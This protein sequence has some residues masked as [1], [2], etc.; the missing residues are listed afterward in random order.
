MSEYFELIK[1]QHTIFALPFAFSGML[2]ARGSHEWPSFA[3]FLWV[4]LA[5]VGGRTAAMALNRVIDAEIDKKNPRTANR[6]IPAGKIKKLSVITLA[7]LSFGLMIFAAWQLPLICRQLLPLAIIILIVYSYTKRFTYLSHFILGGAL[8]AGA[9]G[10]WLA[11]TGEI[12]I[13]VV[14]WG[15]AIMFWVA[16]FDVIYAVQDIEFDRENNLYSL[17][18]WLGTKNSL[19]FSRLFHV[20]TVIFLIS[21]GII[22]K[23][24]L[25]YWLGTGITFLLLVYEHSLLKEDD[26]SRLNMAFFNV[27][28]YISIGMFCFILLDKIL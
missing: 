25:Y 19:L 23:T 24:G 1:F 5:M 20:L 21:L 22:I 6:A 16:G 26:L 28:G 17:P 3:A 9:A 8:A 4:L 7:I 15:F 18:A 11:V 27:N 13:P 2:L 12:T 14:L 10:G